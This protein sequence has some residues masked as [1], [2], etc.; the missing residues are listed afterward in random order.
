MTK[1]KIY[2]HILFLCLSGSVILNA[3]D[4][5]LIADNYFS[6][7]EKMV[8]VRETIW[9]Q[10]QT[11]NSISE[12]DVNRQIILKKD[13]TVDTFYTLYPKERTLLH[14]W[15][16]NYTALLNEIKEKRDFHHEKYN[17]KDTKNKNYRL[18]IY[19]GQDTLLT[20]LIDRT[21][22]IRTELANRISSSDMPNEEKDLLL[23]Y[24]EAILAYKDLS[25]FEPD[26]VIVRSKRYVQS[27]PAAEYTAYVKNTLLLDYRKSAF[28]IGGG[29]FSGFTGLTGD[30]E[31]LFSGGIPMG[32]NISLSVYNISLLMNVVGTP[33]ITKKSFYYHGIWGDG[34]GTNITTSELCLGYNVINNEQIKL[35]PYAGMMNSDF[36]SARIQDNDT[37]LDS[38]DVLN[39]NIFPMYSVGLN[40]EWKFRYLK[41]YSTYKD[42]FKARLNK[43][44]WYLKL[45]AGYG[46]QLNDDFILAQHNN[47]T[48]F[49]IHG[50]GYYI[51]IGIGTFT[52]LTRRNRYHTEQ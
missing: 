27:N 48:A 11:A 36:T 29:F 7:L 50:S 30:L 12:Y 20:G 26:T 32:A 47:N 42:I 21:Y 9:K 37:D 33:A 4:D 43:T 2:L 15:T 45:R 14:F 39:M 52:T 6:G 18:L 38:V 3:Q 41:S 44:Y 10:V 31:N 28:G 24:L 22:S 40:L 51:Q 8:A 1:V 46:F 19:Y 16:G 35:T 23:I 5:S 34:K 17:R 13:N 49:R 25:R